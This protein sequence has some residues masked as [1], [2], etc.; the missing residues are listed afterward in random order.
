MIFT[1]VLIPTVTD[2]WTKLQ[3]FDGN[4]TLGGLKSVNMDF[5]QSD[6]SYGYQNYR[7]TVSTLIHD[8]DPNNCTFCKTEI[9]PRKKNILGFYSNITSKKSISTP[10]TGSY[11]G[12]NLGHV[13]TGSFRYVIHNYGAFQNN[14]TL[15][16]NTQDTLN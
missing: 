15:R 2:A 9:T 4:Y 11:N 1:F 12:A 16:V 3:F 6:P 13:G 10:R 7:L 8:G 5:K 14:G